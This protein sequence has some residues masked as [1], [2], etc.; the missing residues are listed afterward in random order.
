MDYVGIVFSTLVDRLWRAIYSLGNI[1]DW[2]GISV[3]SLWPTTQLDV[4]QAWGRKFSLVTRDSLLGFPYYLES[5]LE[6]LHIYFR[7]FP[8]YYV[9]LTPQI[10]SI[11]DVSPWISSANPISTLPYLV[12]LCL[13]SIS[14]PPIRPIQF[15]P[16]EGDVC[17]SSDLP[18]SMPILRGSLDYSLIL[19]LI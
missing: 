18:A 11:I 19:S 13:S 15:P 10:P 16:P 2:L 17:V 8:L 12:F 5:S 1:L 4:N 9:S 6:S 7:K 3:G 14:S